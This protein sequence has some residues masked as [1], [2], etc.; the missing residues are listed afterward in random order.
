MPG[1]V[2]T[3]MQKQIYDNNTY[4]YETYRSKPLIYSSS[5]NIF[6]KIA[7]IVL[8]GDYDEGKLLKPE[9]TVKRLLEIIDKNQFEN[10]SAI[11]FYDEI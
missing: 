3:E 1:P 10:G 4:I 8:L 2:Y 5:W 7:Y 6:L 9:T 11:D